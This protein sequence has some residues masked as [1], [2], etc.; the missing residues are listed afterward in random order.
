V[1]VALAKLYEKLESWDKLGNLFE[2]I[3]QTAYDE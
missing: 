3:L 2:I 1:T